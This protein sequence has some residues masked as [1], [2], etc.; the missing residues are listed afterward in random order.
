MSITEQLAEVQQNLKC[1]KSQVNGF[2]KYNYRNCED[3]LIKLKEVLNGST[4]TITDDIQQIG[5]RYYIKATATFSDGLESISTTA[6]AREPVQKK[7]MDE[8]QITGAA[9]SYARKYALCGLFALDDNKDADS[10][11]NR[12]AHEEVAYTCVQKDIFDAAIK[13]KDALSFWAL[14][15]VSAEEAYMAL[16]GSFEPGTVTRNKEVCR[17]L[18]PDGAQ[19]WNKLVEN[20]KPMIVAE[21]ANDLTKVIKGFKEHEKRY[22]ANRIGKANSDKLR[23]L[24]KS[25]PKMEQDK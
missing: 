4:I 15:E 21:N 19:K 24:I 12:K 7:G 18:E 1:P 10:Q 14:K 2:G 23:D 5:E 11:D 9:S 3:I 13:K 20:I 17:K 8:S 25:A 16:F 6:F 22:L